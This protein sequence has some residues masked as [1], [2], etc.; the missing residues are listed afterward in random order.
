MFAERSQRSLNIVG[1]SLC[2]ACLIANKSNR[3]GDQSTMAESE[4]ATVGRDVRAIREDDV[5]NFVGITAIR[6]HDHIGKSG[7]G[8][9]GGLNVGRSGR[10]TIGT[11]IRDQRRG[12]I[13]DPQREPSVGAKRSLECDL[14]ELIQF[15]S[16]H[17]SIG[18]K[19]LREDA[20][21]TTVLEIAVPR[22][23]EVAAICNRDIRVALGIGDLVIDTDHAV[24]T[25]LKR[26][27]RPG[28]SRHFAY[29]PVTAAAGPELH[30]VRGNAR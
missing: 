18:I 16:D 5:L 12:G 20:L 3:P 15:R 10:T 13:T 28:E 11:G 9:D 27:E 4:G 6:G 17:I 25:F 23:D 24:E 1:S 29:S 21:S 30:R 7:Q 14:L 22:D 19:S 2:I 26:G 8:I